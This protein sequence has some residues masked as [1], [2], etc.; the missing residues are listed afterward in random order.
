MDY[1]T[2]FHSLHRDRDRLRAAPVAVVG[3]GLP[4]KHAVEA[5]RALGVEPAFAVTMR[6]GTAETF[7]GLPVKTPEGLTP[8]DVAGKVLVTV[9]PAMASRV[10]HLAAQWG[11]DRGAFVEAYR[12]PAPAPAQELSPMPEPMR[13]S[14]EALAAHMERRKAW[15]ER[16][17]AAIRAVCRWAFY[18]YFVLGGAGWQYG[19]S[20]KDKWG[21]LRR[22]LRNAPHFKSLTT[23]AQQLWL[24][25]E[26]FKV[27]VKTRGDVVEC[28]CY[29]G[30]STAILSTA[31]KL[32]GRKLYV[33]DSF[34]GLPEPEADEK[35]TI[36]TGKTFY[37]WKAGEFASPGG[38][39][40]VRQ[41]VAQFGTVESCEFVKGY[42]CDTLPDLP[43]DSAVLV[44]EDADLKSSVV[45]CLKYLWPRLR[46]GCKFFS[47]EP[48]SIEVVS[49][50]FDH[51][52]WKTAFGS[53]PPGFYGG[54]MGGIRTL[55]VYFKMGFAVKRDF[56]KI[57]K[58]GER[59]L[60]S[61]SL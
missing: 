54:D 1:P 16:R 38:L 5:L 58:K 43:V 7:C 36:R 25:H 6:A 20:R 10:P 32:V 46:A 24:C 23:P 51:A 37:N 22:A 41:R 59:V 55:L 48:W 19:V 29:D 13:S 52:F 42:F 15:R 34:E 4:E 39:E 49:L 40:G 53:P 57:V 18:A 9:Q 2:L 60:I 27:S 44:F 8:E 47:H 30:A 35:V 61:G 14:P 26:L 45:D 12:N 3:T 11:V 31:C 33:C 17:Y 56:D 50:F 28:G 21:L